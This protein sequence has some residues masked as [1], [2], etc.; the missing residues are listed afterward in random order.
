[1]TYQESYPVIIDRA[2]ILSI[3]KEYEEAAMDLG[4]LP[5]AVIRRIL[6]PLLFRDL[7]E[8]RDRVR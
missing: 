7:R 5:R 4:A 1:V 8:L 6:L 2:R 3:G